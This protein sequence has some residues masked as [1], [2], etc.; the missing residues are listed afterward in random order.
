MLNVLRK[1]YTE[2]AIKTNKWVT[3]AEYRISKTYDGK[4]NHVNKMRTMIDKAKSMITGRN[5]DGKERRNV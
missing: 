2:R 4:Q 5:K 3:L 1:E